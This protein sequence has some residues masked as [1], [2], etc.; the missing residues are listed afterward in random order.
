MK[1][2]KLK[3]LGLVSGFLW[4]FMSL[5]LWQQRLFDRALN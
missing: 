4:R 5:H 3:A 1:F 2:P